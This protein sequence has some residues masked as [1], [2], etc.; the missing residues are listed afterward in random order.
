MPVRRR[1]TAAEPD[2]LAALWAELER[3]PPGL[4]NEI[5]DFLR[6]ILDAQS[7]VGASPPEGRPR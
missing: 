2:R 1:K 3:L 4:R 5:A 6:T 7:L